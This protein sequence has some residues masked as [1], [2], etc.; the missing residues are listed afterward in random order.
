MKRWMAVLLTGCLT[1]QA[2]MGNVTPVYGAEVADVLEEDGASNA[3]VG[4]LEVEVRSS[5]LFPYNGKV[6][7]KISDSSKTTE[8][9]KE[10]VF[11]SAVVAS[12]RFDTPPGEYTVTVSADKFADYT[13]SVLVEADWVSKIQV[14]SVKPETGSDASAGWFRPGDVSGDGLIDEKDKAEILTAIRRNPHRTD[15]DLNGDGQTD[16]VDLQYFVQSL[17]ESQ[18]SSV[19]KLGLF[20]KTQETEGTTVEGSMEEFLKNAGSISL[21]P[22]DKEA[23]ISLDNPVGLEFVL[24]KDENTPAPQIQGI[25]IQTPSEADEDGNVYSEITDGE[26]IVVC[27][28]EDGSERE[29]V[30]SLAQDSKSTVR[31]RHVRGASREAEASAASVSVDAD[32]S[33]ILDFGRQIAV[34]RVTIKITGTKKE[35]PLVNIAKVE[36]VN[37]MEERIPAPQLD[38]PTLNAPVSENEGLTVS[39]SAQRNVTGYEVCI[40][41]PVKNQSTEETQIVRVSGTQHRIGSINDKPLKNYGKYTIKVR[42]VN[43]DWASPWS[44]EQIGEPRP[45]KIPAPPDNVKADGGYRSIFVSWKDMSDSDGYMVYY[46]K[47]QE[48]SS[49]YRPVVSGFLPVPEGEGRLHDT[50]YTITGLEDDT[51]YSVYVI[52]WNEFGWGK[53]SLVSVAS[54]KSAEP[55]ALPNY[56]RLNTSNGEGKLTAHIVDAA[57]GGHGGAKMVESPLDT[58]VNSALGLVDENYASYWVKADWDDGVSYP[59]LSK[60]VTVTLDN[61]YQMNYLTFAAADEK[62]RVGLV[63]VGY[64]NQESKDVE[65]NVNARLIAKTDERNNN[66]Y[67]VKFDETI[68]ADKIH[69]C[70][71]RSWADRSDMMIGEIHFHSYDSLEDE[72]MGLYEDEMH[73]TLRLDVTDN[74]I[75]SLEERL[76]TV[77]EASGEKHPLYRELKLELMTAREILEAKLAPSVEVDNRITLQKDG[78]LGFGGLNAWQPLGKV[79]YAGESLLVYVGHNTKRTG[80][81]ADLQLVITQYH[82]ESNS[83]ARTVNLKVGINEITIPQLTSN[84]FERGGQLYV[85]YTGNSVSDKY[86][87]RLSGGS[88]IPVLSV[89]GKSGDERI[90]AIR[91]Y[92]GQLESYVNTIQ[93][94]HEERHVG[95]KNVDYAYNQ[96][97]CILNATD[98][99]MKDMMYSVPA[100]Q[101]WAGISGAQ[102]KVTK[103]DNALKAMEKTMT[104]FYQHKGLNDN[105]GTARGN[106]ALPSGHLN[107]RYMRMFAGAFMYAA[108]NHIGVEWGSTTLASAPNSWDSFGW[109]VAHEIGHDINQGTYAIAEITNNY[110]AQLLTIDTKGTRFSY[111]N[112]YRKVTSGAIG[113]SPNVATQLALYWQLHLAFD[114][115]TDDRHIFDDY[116]EQFNNLFFA[117]VDTYS[118]NPSKAPQAGLTLNGGVDQNLMRLACAAANKNILPFFERW[119]MTPDEE[120]VAYAAKYGEPDTKALYYVNDDARDYRAAHSDEAGTVKDQDVVTADV[121]A[122]SNQVE[123]R[124][125]TDRDE[126][127]ILGYEISRSMISNGQKKT[128][129]A[130]FIPIDTSGST[131]FADTLVSVNNRVMDYEVR[132]VDKFLNYSNPVSAG[133]V[134]IQTDGVLIK[135]AWTVETTMTSADDTVLEPD[136]EDPD[137]GYHATNPDSVEEKKVHSIDRVL[138]NDRTNAGT[139]HGVS[140]G[141]A[142]VT[143]DMHKTQEVTALKYFGD[144]LAEVN[145]EVSRDGGTWIPVKTAYK[146][147]T[148]GDEKTVWFDSVKEDTRDSWIGTYDARYVRLTIAQSGDISIKEIEICGPSGDNLEFM[149]TEDGQ[150]AIGV[151]KE[152]YKY[153][154]QDADVIPKGSLIFSGIYKGN[155]AYNVVMLYDTDG[156]VIGAKDGKVQAG[157]VIFADVP[158]QGNLGETSDGTWVYY[159]EPDQWDEAAL[160]KIDGVRGEVYR[161][162]DALTL[163]GERIVSDTLVIDIPDSLPELT[164]TGTVF[165]RQ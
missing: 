123:I 118:R 76:E 125:A 38:I 119:G 161:V 35:E 31:S 115:N 19:V 80:D 81:A 59:G 50:R 10:L 100:T 22:S 9:S 129:V 27:A 141:T 150:P 66:Y 53:A 34:K 39:W 68:T 61:E 62:S 36:F 51:Q 158:A 77:D 140:E 78:H 47:S 95:T 157:Q 73:T 147:L 12:A 69:L 163:E 102:D 44:N 74:T 87:V 154:N 52:S 37:N 15:T 58:T 165:E 126:D 49:A 156:N 128:E 45:Q 160:K 63:R 70:L 106:N 16:I 94:S 42:S 117:R 97:N 64:W 2:W 7:V 96:G 93:A 107:I 1:L 17:D 32:G 116:E 13:Q 98:I 60:G 162:D 151:L 108:G 83:L 148:G 149:R 152:D 131:V 21:L 110:F 109:G 143:I 30:F 57:M 28:E 164:L 25:T 33:L 137:S 55:P 85:A 136:A 103:L 71:G 5:A 144:A 18:E 139:Y 120:T 142:S 29:V 88:D 56:K 8:E 145:I 84:D 20:K 82:A 79:A 124:I 72:I 153:G 90:E 146:G 92:V 111:P 11:G 138:D 101:V 46:K 104:L 40:S 105:A 75:Q 134:K 14:S 43:G 99:M 135:D 24:A 132:A 65:Q 91:T 112:V 155:P 114:D 4:V 133:T 41:G 121:T 54:T 89:Y 3:A 86:A 122:K 26:A 48:D 113:R 23:P 127:L 130:G 6:T 67:I 159:I